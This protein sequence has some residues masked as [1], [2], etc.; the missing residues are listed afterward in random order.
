MATDCNP[1]YTPFVVESPV[2]YEKRAIKQMVL[3]LL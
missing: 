2:I 3:N 1:P